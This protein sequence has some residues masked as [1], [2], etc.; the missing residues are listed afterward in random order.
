MPLVAVS[1]QAPPH[2]AS[3]S[4]HCAAHAARSQTS[5]AAQA[6]PQAPQFALSVARFTHV[7]PHD[8]C[9]DGHSHA[10]AA[11]AVPPEHLTPHAPQLALSPVVST[12]APPHETR[13]TGQAAM[14]R[15]NEH[16]S[17]A[18]QAWPHVPQLF[19]SVPSFT[20]ALP[21][22]VSPRRQTQRPAR[23]SFVPSQ[24]LPQAPQFV[25]SDARSTQAPLQGERPIW[26]AAAQ[27][28]CE[29][30]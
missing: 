27:C 30:T 16:D 11:H 23:H 1:T 6:V 9:P 22:A 2:I 3:G 28:P 19:G 7:P 24:A 21:H 17:L 18:A 4:V 8:T 12:H 13:P 10:P 20:H 26:Q 29:Q 14:Q 5:V 15:P 25:A